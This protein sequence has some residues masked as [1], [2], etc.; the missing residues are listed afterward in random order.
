MLNLSTVEVAHDRAV[1]ITNK[2]HTLHSNTTHTKPTPKQNAEIDLI[3]ILSEIIHICQIT[4]LKTW[5][6]NGDF[7]LGILL[8]CLVQASFNL[9]LQLLLDRANDHI[10]SQRELKI[11]LK[12]KQYQRI[13]GNKQ[14]RKRQ[15]KF[16]GLALPKAKYIRYFTPCSVTYI[17]PSIQDLNFFLEMWKELGQ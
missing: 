8:R 12:P 1:T 14:K 16:K 13:L 10:L 3:C 17:L 11:I 7:S 9:F 4:T 15:I 6:T 2:Y 5:N